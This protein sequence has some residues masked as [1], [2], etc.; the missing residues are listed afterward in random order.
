M[1]EM[2]TTH[3]TVKS[4][5]RRVEGGGQKLHVDSFFS[6]PD[7]SDDV[8]IRGIKTVVGL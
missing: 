3:A 8:R 7:L 6:S 2:T 4:L 1:Q 5:T